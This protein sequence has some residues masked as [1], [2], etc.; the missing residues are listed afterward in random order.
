MIIEWEKQPEERMVYTVFDIF[1]AL[2]EESF[3]LYELSLM[4][5]TSVKELQAGVSSTFR[6]I[7]ESLKV[8]KYEVCLQL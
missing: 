2:Q 7:F 3:L 8:K 5:K 6:R 4:Y 1:P